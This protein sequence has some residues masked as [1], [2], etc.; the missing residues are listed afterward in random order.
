ME[1][2]MKASK[3]MRTVLIAG[4]L[5]CVSLGAASAGAQTAAGSYSTAWQQ[6]STLLGSTP[7]K[8]NSTSVDN[9]PTQLPSLETLLKQYY[10]DH[11][12][13]ALANIN[14]L[15]KSSFPSQVLPDATEVAFSDLVRLSQSDPTVAQEL[16]NISTFIP[17]S[18]QSATTANLWSTVDIQA[19]PVW[20]NGF[21]NTTSFLG[22]GPTT[23]SYSINIIEQSFAP[24]PPHIA[25]VVEST[26]NL[27]N[28]SGGSLVIPTAKVIFSPT[29]MD[30][31]NLN[32][33]SVR[34]FYRLWRYGN[35]NTNKLSPINPK[36]S[37]KGSYD[38]TLIESGVLGGTGVTDPKPETDTSGSPTNKGNYQFVVPVPNPGLNQFRIDC[39]RIMGNGSVL[40]DILTDNPKDLN[41]L[42]PWFTGALDKVATVDPANGLGET[43]TNPALGFLNGYNAQFEVGELSDIGSVYISGQA[44]GLS[45]FGRIDLAADPID[46]SKIYMSIPSFHP[47]GMPA[48]GSGVVFRYDGKNGQIASVSYQPGFMTPGQAG[49]ALGQNKCLYTD[50]SASDG[51]FGGRLF[52]LTA[53]LEPADTAYAPSYPIPPYS[54]GAKHPTDSL[55]A[56]SLVGS[57][58][59]YS[60]LLGSANPVSAQQIV[61]G[62]NEGDAVGQQLYVADAATNTIKR[63][64]V[65][66]GELSNWD[67]SHTVGQPW[68]STDASGKTPPAAS[69][70]LGFTSTTDMAFSGDY[71]TLY[72]T[73]GSYV[74]RTQGGVNK[75]SSITTGGTLFTNATG[76][77]TCQDAGQEYLFIADG[78]AGSILRIPVSDI[79]IAVPSDPQQLNLMMQKY[80][81]L[82]GLNNPGELRVTDDSRGMVMVDNGSLYY[83]HFGFSGTA[84][85]T[86][87]NPLSGATVTADTTSGSISTKT[88]GSGNFNI[89]AGTQQS[90]LTVHIN[91]PSRSYTEQITTTGHCFSTSAG[92]CVDITSPA[93]GAQ[94]NTSRT[95]VS[96]TIFPSS[97]S[98]AASG[99][100]LL[101][102]GTDSYP[103]TFTGNHNDFTVAG[104]NL[105]DGENTLAVFTNATSGF[106]A[107]GS[108]P[109][110]V[111]VTGGPI[112]TQAYSGV[113]TD[114]NDVAQPGKTVNISVNGVQAATTTTNGCGY[115]NATGLPLGPVTT[116]VVQ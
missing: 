114:S 86:Q 89:V 20:D 38:L 1:D 53:F 48:Q 2:G 106:Q 109:T 85:D 87:G 67:P 99:G 16:T 105:T 90:P 101:V 12:E 28:V 19:G 36:A 9:N 27:G 61:L 43:F 59:Y 68:A 45:Q 104:V 57:V 71:S 80:T 73:Q 35:P 108:L 44:S 110:K 41:S 8:V 63:V 42:T 7:T 54:D 94:L 10:T 60:Q 15:L 25:K 29:A 34:Y 47:S 75:S 70:Q 6:L 115:Y 21:A 51:Q 88:D 92:P 5:A 24:S 72:I 17:G 69:D 84:V 55:P 81:F 76:V 65:Q 13:T 83:Q 82:T 11:S 49:L 78:A 91:H 74:V 30:K 111:T 98:F 14:T 64:A 95:T 112:A 3:S 103:L 96:G 58:N 113:I 50:N 46:N 116:Q 31:L 79:P 40:A 37:T 22:I 102:N 56:R 52:R 77:A 93:N 23:A 97:V 33:P 66:R 32:D 26:E 100:N 62:K 39:V 107:G 18:K 4:A